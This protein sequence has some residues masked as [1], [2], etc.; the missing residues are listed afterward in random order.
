VQRLGGIAA[1]ETGE[2]PGPLEQDPALVVEVG[3]SGVE[4]PQPGLGVVAPADRVE[5]DR[6]DEDAPR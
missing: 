6:A 5:H 4:L 1:L 2:A 3:L